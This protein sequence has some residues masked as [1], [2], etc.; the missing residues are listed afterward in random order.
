M[1]SCWCFVVIHGHKAG[2]KKRP[3][4]IR[5]YTRH[6]HD[7]E[8]A[9][10]T[11]VTQRNQ[12]APWDFGDVLGTPGI[13]VASSASETAAPSQVLTHLACTRQ[14]VSGRVLLRFLPWDSGDVLGAPSIPV[15]MRRCTF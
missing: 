4:A 8:S 12:A 9:T 15:V 7:T 11:A 3:G 6:M 10:V 1:C 13:P 5:S 14:G 2:E